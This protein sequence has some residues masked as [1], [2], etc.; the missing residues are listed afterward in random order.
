MHLPLQQ[1]LQGEDAALAKRFAPIAEALKRGEE[2]ILS[3]LNGAQGAAVDIG[4]Y[5]LP[6]AARASAAMR[7]SAAL[8]AIIDGI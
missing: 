7:P 1:I 3:E 6:D 4:G 2:A 5:Y 8:N